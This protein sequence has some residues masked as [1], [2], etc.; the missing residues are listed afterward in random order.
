MEKYI[1]SD[2]LC[3]II[4]VVLKNDIFKFGKKTLK[5]KTVYHKKGYTIQPGI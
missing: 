1:P 2:T 3:D 5:Q 4:E